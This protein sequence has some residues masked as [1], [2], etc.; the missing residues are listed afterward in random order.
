MKERKVKKKPV[1]VEGQIRLKIV[2][3]RSRLFLLST[4]YIEYF[5]QS[6]RLS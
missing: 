3:A 1:Q 4:I 5:I 6:I 2:H